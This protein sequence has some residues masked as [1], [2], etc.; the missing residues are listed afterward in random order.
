MYCCCAP[1]LCTAAA[2]RDCARCVNLQA[3]QVCTAIC[4]ADLGR[5]TCSKA[6][7]ALLFMIRW[8]IMI[9]QSQTIHQSSATLDVT[10][11]R[12]TRAPML[13]SLCIVAIKTALAV[14]CCAPRC[15]WCTGN[16]RRGGREWCTRCVYVC[17]S[18]ACAPPA[19]LMLLAGC[20]HDFHSLASTQ[21]QH[22]QQ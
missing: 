7:S 15:C 10:R 20:Q 11:D 2:Q 3:H 19:C 9:K 16:A 21:V 18:C 22:T 4:S 6:A 14:L 13:E 1:S 12:V 5:G 8:R 17:A